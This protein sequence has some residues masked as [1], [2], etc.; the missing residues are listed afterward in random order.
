MV[1]L[2]LMVLCA[3][4]P[5]IP[6]IA[7]IMGIRVGY[8]GRGRLERVFGDGLYMV[9]GHPNGAEVWEFARPRSQLYAEGFSY[10]AH[11]G[12]TIE[13]LS[14]MSDSKEDAGKWRGA[15]RRSRGWL[16]K[17]YLGMQQAEALQ[18]ASQRLG[19]PKINKGEYEWTQTGWSVPAFLNGQ[20]PL[21]TWTATL[22]C[23]KGKVKSVVV[24]SD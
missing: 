11:E 3:R 21:K 4:P 20:D 18:L 13:H 24:S 23:A 6:P 7:E 9:G 2:L 16:G 1:P 14:W 12:E 19:Q 5:H 22:D 17:I 15:L 10:T 8:D